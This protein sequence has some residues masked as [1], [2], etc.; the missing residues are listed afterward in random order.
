MEQCGKCRF[1]YFDS[2]LND[3]ICVN[4]ESDYC[5]VET[6]YDD[7]CFDFEVKSSGY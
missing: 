7:G 6:A 3:W 2:D 4:P 1:H 5:G